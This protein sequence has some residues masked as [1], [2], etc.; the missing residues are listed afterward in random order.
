MKNAP[1]ESRGVDLSTLQS[2]RNGAGTHTCLL[3]I[4]RRIRC[5]QEMGVCPGFS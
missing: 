5:A 2:G 4:G 1:A 3:T